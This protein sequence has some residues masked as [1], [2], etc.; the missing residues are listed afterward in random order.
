[1]GNPLGAA[2]RAWLRLATSHM[3]RN[4]QARVMT[5]RRAEED[6]VD[7][8]LQRK[9]MVESQVRPSDVTDRRII[10]AMGEIPRELFAPEAVR[11]LAYM[12]S[13]IGL[14]ADASGATRILLEPR[15]FAKLVQSAEIDEASAVLDVGAATGYSTAVLA[16]LGRHVVALESDAALADQARETLAKIGVE[17]V[18]VVTGPLADGVPTAGPFDAIVIEGAVEVVPPGL[19]DQLKDGGRLVA[20]L[21]RNGTGR[22]TVWRRGSGV[23]GTQEVFDAN[24]EVLPGFER[25]AEFVF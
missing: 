14:G 5:D 23:Y 22:A 9:N 2:S 12:D 17:G 18:E 15:A 7:S 25:A 16:Q 6:Q 24:A 1:M 11:S 13:A 21:L 19:L 4:V 3:L 10:R 20:I 8:N